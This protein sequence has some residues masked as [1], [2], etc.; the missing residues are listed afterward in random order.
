MQQ[1]HPPL[2]QI[3]LRYDAPLQ[4]YARRLVKDPAIAAALVKEVFEHVYHLN[5][6]NVNDKTLRSLFKGSVFKMASLWLLHR[7]PVTDLQN[8][9][10]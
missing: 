10:A 2:A 9:K 1:T 7:S 5:G 6:F 8:K 3:I 4:R